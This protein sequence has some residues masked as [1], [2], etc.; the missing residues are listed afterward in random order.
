M[1]A[2][3]DSCTNETKQTVTPDGP[4]EDEATARK[5]LDAVGYDPDNLTEET[6]M[7][8]MKRKRTGPDVKTPLIHFCWNED[9][10]LPVLLQGC[11]DDGTDTEGILLPAIHGIHYGELGAVQVAVRTRRRKGHPTYHTEDSPHA[12]ESCICICKKGSCPRPL[13]DTQ[14]RFLQQRGYW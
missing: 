13:A 11:L 6:F 10:P 4:I 3:T 12:S 8:T 9:G 5:K 2:K 7:E 14:R 1:K